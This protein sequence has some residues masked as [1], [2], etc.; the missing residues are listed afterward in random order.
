MSRRTSVS[1]KEE[2]NV[3]V[4]GA[5]IAASLSR[6][7]VGP[8]DRC[9]DQ[10]QDQ[11]DNGRLRQRHPRLIVEV[12]V[13]G[14]VLLFKV[15]SIPSVPSRNATSVGRR[16]VRRSPQLALQRGADGVKIDSSPSVT[17]TAVVD[18]R[19]GR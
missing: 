13:R 10:D 1:R 4:G 6:R 8:A 17:V 5:G 11:D 15:S 12:S 16:R 14:S 2:D 7:L 3:W 19:R 9:Q 18:K